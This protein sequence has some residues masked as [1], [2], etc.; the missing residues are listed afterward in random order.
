M[1]TSNA[2]ESRIEPI[3]W[4]A[5]VRRITVRWDGKA[6]VV[7]SEVRVASMTLPEPDGLTDGDKSRGFWIESIDTHGRVRYREVMT[8][9]RAG[10]EQFDDDGQV[11]RL[12]HAQHDVTIELLVP[13]V[14][15]IAELHLVSN[16]PATVVNHGG[17]SWPA[18]SVLRLSPKAD[19]PG[20]GPPPP[21]S[22]GQ[23]H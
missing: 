21:P 6:W 17:K 11:T 1:T 3:Q 7:M 2:F 4:P 13:D 14:V 9:P 10:M 23:K 20:G 5:P 12:P 18:R 16:P 22:G 15:G 8:D 19:E